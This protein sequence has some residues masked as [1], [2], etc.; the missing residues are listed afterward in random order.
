M[1]RRLTVDLGDRDVHDASAF[2]C[3]DDQDEQQPVGKRLDRR[4]VS[5]PSL[6]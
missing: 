1:P 3:E 6:A 5:G 2:V 4:E